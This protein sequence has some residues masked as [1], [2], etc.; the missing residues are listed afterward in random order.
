MAT[1]E[2]LVMS[3][4]G[5]YLRTTFVGTDKNAVVAETHDRVLGSV[6][7]EDGT[8]VLSNVGFHIPKTFRVPRHGK[9]KRITVLLSQFVAKEKVKKFHIRSMTGGTLEL[10]FGDTDVAADADYS[11]GVTDLAE[12]AKGGTD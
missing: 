2:G 1:V 12:F 11:I 4:V 6:E 8:T 9:G 7:T 5:L 3:I 10:W